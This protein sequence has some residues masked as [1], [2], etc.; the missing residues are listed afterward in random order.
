MKRIL[1]KGRTVVSVLV[2]GM[3]I[4]CAI[5]PILQAKNTYDCDGCRTYDS[6]GYR[7]F[8][9]VKAFDSKGIGLNATAGAEIG[10]RGVF[11]N[12]GS[13]NVTV[14]SNYSGTKAAAHHAFG[15]GK[16]L[17]HNTWFVRN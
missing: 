11:T 10:T 7:S 16:D 9:E 15:T 2:L 4:V 5:S 6:K 14:Y 1:E 17:D 12:Y 8:T 13:G 3:M